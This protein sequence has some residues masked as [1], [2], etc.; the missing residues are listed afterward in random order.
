MQFTLLDLKMN[1]ACDFYFFVLYKY[2]YLLMNFTH[3]T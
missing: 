1:G 2:T 3:L